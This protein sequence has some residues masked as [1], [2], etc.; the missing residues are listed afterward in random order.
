MITPLR[1]HLVPRVTMLFSPE[2]APRVFRLGILP[3]TSARPF[4]RL[5]GGAR[6]SLNIGNGLML[7]RAIL[8]DN[9]Y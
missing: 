3:Q 7:P 8:I 1:I 2:I 9:M 6:L 5:D 4:W